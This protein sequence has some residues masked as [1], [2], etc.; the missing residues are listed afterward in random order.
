MMR[1]EVGGGE[2]KKRNKRSG[3]L[4]TSKSSAATY[5]RRR[6]SG[7]CNFCRVSGFLKKDIYQNFINVCI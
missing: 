3:K 6:E 5:R 2:E 4:M 1:V 7:M